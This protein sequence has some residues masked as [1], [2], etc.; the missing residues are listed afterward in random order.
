MR[1]SGHD[2][3]AVW[4]KDLPQVLPSVFGVGLRPTQAKQDASVCFLGFGPPRK[5]GFFGFPLKPNKKGDHIR[6]LDFQSCAEGPGQTIEP[7]LVLVVALS[8]T[9]V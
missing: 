2:G 1:L 8:H 3:C 4:L 7:G 9:P 5:V 6:P